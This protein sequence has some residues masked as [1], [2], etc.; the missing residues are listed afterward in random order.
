MLF[1]HCPWKRGSSYSRPDQQTRAVKKP[2][3][4][5]LHMS[6][7]GWVS[8]PLGDLILFN[9]HVPYTPIVLPLSG[10]LKKKKEILAV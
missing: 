1:P 10:N 2:Y 9:A 8:A 3:S 5:K 6:E 7:Q 4:S